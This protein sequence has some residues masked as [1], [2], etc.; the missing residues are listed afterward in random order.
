MSKFSEAQIAAMCRDSTLIDPRADAGNTEAEARRPSV[1]KINHFPNAGG[2]ANGYQVIEQVNAGNDFQGMIVVPVDA[3]DN[4]DWANVTVVYAATDT[5]ADWGADAT[6]FGAGSTAGQPDAAL[7]LA[8]RAIDIS[9]EHGGEG[10]VLFT[11]HSMGGGYAE[12]AAARFGTSCLTFAAAD[13]TILMSPADRAWADAHPD[14]LIDIRSKD[15]AVTGSS[16][17]LTTGSINRYGITWF[18]DGDGHDLGNMDFNDDGTPRIDDLS[19]WDRYIL[20]TKQKL[21]RFGDLLL[22]LDPIAGRVLITGRIK[23]AVQEA[24]TVAIGPTLDMVVNS[25][26]ETMSAN[27]RI[28]ERMQ[29][30]FDLALATAI[31]FGGPGLDRARLQQEIINRRLEPRFHFDEDAV[32]RTHYMMGK[33]AEEAATLKT[34]IKAVVD[35]IIATDQQGAFAFVMGG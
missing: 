24:E 18:I 32:A 9:R 15:D 19:A 30:A 33:M 8:Q 1:G 23:V 12:W 14:R 28:P 3:N 21:W 11:G 27:D 2:E 31:A 34:R 17:N 22:M 26:Q 13:P 6:A 35:G 4:P 25:I 5:P 7:D 16:N 20:E 29:E 10:Q